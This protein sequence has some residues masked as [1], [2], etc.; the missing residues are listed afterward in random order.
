[1]KNLNLLSLTKT[2]VSIRSDIT[3]ERNEGNLVKY[4]TRYLSKIPGLEVEK[5]IVSKG[6]CNI[7]AVKGNPDIFLLGHMDTVPVSK[8]VQLK[9]KIL[10]GRL[11]GRGSVD[12]K[13]G[14]AQMLLL[15]KELDNIGLIFTVD[16]EY[17]FLGM[18]KL[19]TGFK[20]RP[21]LII[22]LEPTDLD[23]VNGCRGICEFELEVKGKSAHSSIKLEGINAVERTIEFCSSLEKNLRKKDTFGRTTLNLAYINGGSLIDGKIVSV[24]NVVPDFTKVLIEIRFGYEGIN[25]KKLK[26]E[27]LKEAKRQGI[28]VKRIKLNFLLG[29]MYSK[30]KYLREF[31]KELKEKIKKIVYKDVNRTGYFEAQMLQE[32]CKCECIVFGAGPSTQAHKSDE[33]V[34]IKQLVQSYGIL[35]KFLK[36][37]TDTKN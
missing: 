1:M 27:I 33:F 3:S 8:D 15:S 25:W 24:G 28:T 22:N 30:G 2:I 26:K 34:D 18:K 35:L 12:M 21:K 32:L 5:Q 37:N 23:I 17:Q 14:L 4:I 29:S 31:E 7:V 20:Y 6:R 11:Y 16:E 19:I 13:A 36:R 10:N 9:P